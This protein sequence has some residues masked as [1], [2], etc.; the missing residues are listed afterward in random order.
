MGVTERGR[1]PR[2]PVIGPA[3]P[4]EK[5]DT[6]KASFNLGRIV[7][8]TNAHRTLN[9]EDV[10]AALARHAAGDW[11]EVGPEDWREND[12]SLR[13]GFRILSAYRDRAGVKF[14]IITEADRS[15]TTVLLPEDY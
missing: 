12:L 6:K 10:M 7:A 4:K 3:I 1:E 5:M 15:A 8:T 9:P 11:G 13:E 14:W 2:E